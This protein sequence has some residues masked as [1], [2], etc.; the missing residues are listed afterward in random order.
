MQG[1]QKI[2]PVHPRESAGQGQ[3]RKEHALPQAIMLGMGQ[4]EMD[5]RE[6]E[7]HPDAGG[8]IR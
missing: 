5:S 7:G 1:D 6:A 8:Y 2:C 3:H 4:T